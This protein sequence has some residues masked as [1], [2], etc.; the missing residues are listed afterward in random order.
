MKDPVRKNAI[1]ATTNALPCYTYLASS[2]PN[3][4]L[5]LADNLQKR[6]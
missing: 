3:S 6:R 4:S 5:A 1:C 2:H